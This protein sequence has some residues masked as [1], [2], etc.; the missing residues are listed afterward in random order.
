MTARPL[1]PKTPSE[2]E[3]LGGGAAGAQAPERANVKARKRARKRRKAALASLRALFVAR[4]PCRACGG[5]GA[6]FGT[7]HDAPFLGNC[8][9]CLGAGLSPEGCAALAAE[10]GKPDALALPFQLADRHEGARRIVLSS[11]T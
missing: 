7:A 1:T 6:R 9:K 5:S 4:H 2:P 11:D 3:A 8:R 10:L